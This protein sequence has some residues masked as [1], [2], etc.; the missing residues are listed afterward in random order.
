[1]KGILK[2]VIVSFNINDKQNDN[3]PIVFRKSF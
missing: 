1:M 3:E 2:V